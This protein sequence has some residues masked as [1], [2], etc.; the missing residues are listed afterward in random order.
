MIGM[1]FERAQAEHERQRAQWAVDNTKLTA[2]IQE[3]FVKQSQVAYPP[4]FQ[5]ESIMMIMM[6]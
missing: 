1:H 2:F 3:L 5:R 4:P 6:M